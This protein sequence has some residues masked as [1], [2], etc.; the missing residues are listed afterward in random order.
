MKNNQILLLVLGL[1][2]VVI[3][4]AYVIGGGQREEIFSG[5]ISSE[6]IKDKCDWWNPGDWFGNCDSGEKDLTPAEGEKIDKDKGNGGGSG[7]YVTD[8]ND[9][10]TGLPV[11]GG[12]CP[13]GS[14]CVNVASRGCACP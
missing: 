3:V 6:T 11:C 12:S 5:G 13:D 14:A 9:P 8:T 2:V 7:C 10:D 1:A 4:S